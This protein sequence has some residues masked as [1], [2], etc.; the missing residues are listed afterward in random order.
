M[1]F[2]LAIN[3][4]ITEYIQQGD[5]ILL[6]NKLLSENQV[7]ESSALTFPAEALGFFVGI[8]GVVGL[9]VIVAIFSLYVRNKKYKREVSLYFVQKKVI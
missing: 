9:V 7:L 5:S 1:Y 3:G 6:Q 2:I 8:F 4:N